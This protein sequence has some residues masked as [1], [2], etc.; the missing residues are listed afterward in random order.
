MLGVKRP[1]GPLGALRFEN[2]PHRETA[3]GSLLGSRFVPHSPSFS[4]GT[5]QSKFVL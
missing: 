1:K 2:R 4:L 5:A 3:D